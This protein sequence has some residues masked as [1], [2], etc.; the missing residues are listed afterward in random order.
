MPALLLLQVIEKKKVSDMDMNLVLWIQSIRTRT[1]TKVLALVHFFSTPTR[2]H[3]KQ[4]TRTRTCDLCT[5]PNPG[6]GHVDLVPGHI[7]FC[8]YMPDWASDFF[9]QGM[10][11]LSQQYTE[12]LQGLHKYWLGNWKILQGT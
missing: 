10:Y 9:S 5:C 4:S 2:T 7:N 8:G 1:Q 6:P 11:L 3:A 12:V